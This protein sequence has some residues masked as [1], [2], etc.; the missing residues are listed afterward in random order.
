MFFFLYLT[1]AVRLDV[2]LAA[3]VST[4]LLEYES[5]ERTEKHPQ[6]QKARIHTVQAVRQQ[7]QFEL[8]LIII[9]GKMNEKL[10]TNT[11]G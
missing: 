7:A 1:S 8:V 2:V 11:Y 9:I 5:T 3:A 4:T 10:G 6:W